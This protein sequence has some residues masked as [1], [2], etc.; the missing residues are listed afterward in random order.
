MKCLALVSLYAICCFPSHSELIFWCSWLYSLC[1]YRFTRGSQLH[2]YYLVS[3]DALL[4]QFTYPFIKIFSSLSSYRSWFVD[5]FVS[6]SK[7]SSQC[8]Y[9]RIL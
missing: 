1:H 3:L 9:R 6:T 4:V 5:I 7:M 2:N 8:V